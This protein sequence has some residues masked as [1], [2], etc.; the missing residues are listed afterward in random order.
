MPDMKKYKFPDG[1]LW[2]AATAAYQIEGA[3]EADGR[4]VS[5]WDTFCATPGKI[6]DGSSGKD[7]CRHYELMESDLDLIKSYNLGSYRFS[8]AWPRIIP[9]G[10]GQVNEKGLDFYERLVDGL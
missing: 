9:G 1:F 10:T 3:T 8:L 6:K 2:G 5:V 4:G 7:A